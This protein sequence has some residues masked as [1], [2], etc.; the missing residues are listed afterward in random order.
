[1]PLITRRGTAFPGRVA[2]SLL[3]AAGLP[4]LVTERAPEYLALALKLAKDPLAL[5][6]VRKKLA[7]NKAT[8]PLFDTQRFTRDLERA[9]T[10]MVDRARKGEAPA[11]FKVS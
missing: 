6:A 3:V 9:Y 4:E 8:S 11:S 1:V 2:A 5:S 10:M 7:A